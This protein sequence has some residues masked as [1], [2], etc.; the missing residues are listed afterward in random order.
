MQECRRFPVVNILPRFV[1]QPVFLQPVGR[2]TSVQ[3]FPCFCLCMSA[4][5]LFLKSSTVVRRMP[6]LAVTGI[7]LLVH[8][9]GR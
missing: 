3:P 1:P 7:L 5:L 9:C 4:G 6:G 8:N 2:R